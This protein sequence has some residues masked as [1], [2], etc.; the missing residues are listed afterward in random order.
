V[1]LSDFIQLCKNLCLIESDYNLT[2]LYYKL[3]SLSEADMTAGYARDRVF[4]FIIS[5]QKPVDCIALHVD[6]YVYRNT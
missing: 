5:K 1:S 3:Q 4:L 6:P 2:K